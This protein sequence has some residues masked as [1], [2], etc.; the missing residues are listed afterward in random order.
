MYG[1]CVMCGRSVLP[2]EWADRVAV[3]SPCSGFIHASGFDC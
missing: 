1:S 3:F 2:G